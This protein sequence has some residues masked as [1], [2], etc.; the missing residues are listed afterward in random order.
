MSTDSAIILVSR[1]FFLQAKVPLNKTNLRFWD[2]EQKFF[3]C[4]NILNRNQYNGDTFSERPKTGCTKENVNAVKALL[5]EKAE[6]D[7]DDQNI[8]NCRNNY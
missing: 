5:D 1:T 7:S 3:T 6:K 2:N 8:N 4:D